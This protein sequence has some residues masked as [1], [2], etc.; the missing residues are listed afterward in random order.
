MLNEIKEIIKDII[1]DIDTLKNDIDS[2]ED[3][4]TTEDM[5]FRDWYKRFNSIIYNL[6]D[7]IKED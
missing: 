7:I 4:E 3:A 1:D 2:Y 5:D 6:E